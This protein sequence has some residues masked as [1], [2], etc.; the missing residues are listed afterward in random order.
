MS[1]PDLAPESTKPRRGRR[2][3]LILG[4]VAT[5]LILL[6]VGYK[7]WTHGQESTD[8]AQV[9]ADVVPMAAQTG[10]QV[11]QVLIAENQL[12]AK[13]DAILQIDDVDHKARL[14]QAQ[15]ELAAARAQLDVATANEQVSTASARGGLSSAQASLSGSSEG[16]ANADAQIAAARAALARA[17]AEEHQSSLDLARAQAL[18]KDDAIAQASLDQAIATHD[19]AL[20][21]LEQAT[22][23]L[24]VTEQQKRM[25]ESRVAEAQGKLAQSTPIDAQI[26]AAK[27]ATALAA[28]RVQSAEAQVTLA[29]TQLGYTRVT[30]PIAGIASRLGVH[31]GQLVSVG[32]PVVELVPTQTYVIANFKETQVGAMRPG[33]RAEVDVD[34]FSRHTLEGRVESISGGTGSR[35]SVLPPDNASGNFV[36]VV[37]R[38]PVRILFTSPPDV[39]LRAGMSCDVTVHVSGG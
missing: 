10:G 16:V 13:G 17:R 9:E 30:A 38:V 12:L 26:A 33:D 19:G 36:K 11:K 3:Y 5:G 32:Q 29:Q 35:F 24:A 4:A 8:D 14:A 27:A 20:A 39:P 22:A 2:A 31:A 23:N 34:A 28:A 15:A 21:A 18:R 7:V 1:T 6:Y 25:A 37:Q